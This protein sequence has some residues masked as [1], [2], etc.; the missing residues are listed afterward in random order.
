MK[1]LII[2]DANHQFLY[3]FVSDLK[4]YFN[5]RIQI[6]I[7]STS[8]SPLKES[9]QVYDQVYTP[10]INSSLLSLKG[11][12]IWWRRLILKN[13]IRR[14]SAQYDICNIHYADKDILPSVN[15][16]KKFSKKII[17]SIWGS[18]IYRASEKILDR[19]KSYYNHIDLV[20]FEN[21]HTMEFFDNVFHLPKKK[22]RFFTFHLK[23]LELM[24]NFENVSAEECKRFFDIDADKIII[25]LGYSASPGAQ[26]IRLLETLKRDDK[27]IEL[28]SKICF[29]FPLTYPKDNK[30]LNKIKQNLNSFPFE[31]KLFLNFMSNEQIAY[32]RKASDI[33]VIVTITDQLSGSLLEHLYAGNVVL[34]GE[35]LPYKVLEEKGVF[36]RK[37]TKSFD[38]LT[39]QLLSII[40][41][42]EIEKSRSFTNN[43]IIAQMNDWNM[44]MKNWADIYNN[45]IKN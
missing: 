37:V 28:K 43:K 36:F 40:D 5:N 8:R 16:I 15:D 29:F 19:Q 13:F 39:E 35:W 3:N 45:V 4:Q 25:T 33:F 1:I 12:R 22:Y 26:H 10:L 30:Y 2:G 21:Q 14:I 41:N 7:L 17:C 44:I 20:T 9:A 34:A 18:D 38:N 23:P 42:L 11:F 27:L 24:K 31:Y 6:D 32:L